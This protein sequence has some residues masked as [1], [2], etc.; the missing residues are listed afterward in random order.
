MKSRDSRFML[1]LLIGFSLIFM[2]WGIGFADKIPAPPALP[3][4]PVAEQLYL[5]TLYDN[6][7]SF[8]VVTTTPDGSRSGQKGDVLVFLNSGTDYICINVDGSTDWK[9]A[10]LS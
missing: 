9:C 4:E 8:E 2:F 7:H 6:I 3:D 5:K 1:R 10:L